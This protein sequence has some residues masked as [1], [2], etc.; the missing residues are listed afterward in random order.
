MAQTDTSR[1]VVL[2]FRR[3]AA[4]YV[5]FVFSSVVCMLLELMTVEFGEFQVVAFKVF[6]GVTQT[7]EYGW[8]FGC[9]IIGMGAANR[10]RGSS[11]SGRAV[12]ARMVS[13]DV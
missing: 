3:F 6:A 10:T 11:S 2:L 1:T 7:S 4:L 5:T 12:R 13:L 9:R 8:S